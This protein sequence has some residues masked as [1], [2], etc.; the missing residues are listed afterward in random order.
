MTGAAATTTTTA[1]NES[2]TDGNQTSGT[3]STAGDTFTAI[4]T[5]ADLDKVI[6]DR[7]AR[8]RGKY[9]DYADLQAKAAE[10][11]KLADAN[12]SELEKANEKANAAQAEAEKVP[13]KVADALKTYLVEL[14]KDV[15]DDEKAGLFL[16]ASTPE[17][18]LKQVQA[19][20]G[21]EADRKK[22][23]NRAPRE[24]LTPDNSGSEGDRA[25]VRQVFGGSE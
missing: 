19:L 18:L 25:F 15:I 11:D 2:N 6:G 4:T 3:T 17:L 5:Q 10:F 16:T 14:H 7:V 8:E 23:G 24:G 9:A 20:V 1:T 22:N 12:K 13:A 21:T